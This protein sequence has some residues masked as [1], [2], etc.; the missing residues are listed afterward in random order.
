MLWDS[1]L[2]RCL[3]QFVLARDT[4]HWLLGELTSIVTSRLPTLEKLQQNWEIPKLKA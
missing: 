1:A 3:G 4:S 2:K